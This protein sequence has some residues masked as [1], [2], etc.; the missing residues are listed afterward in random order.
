MDV[1]TGIAAISL[2]S[3]STF[4]GFEDM[5]NVAEDESFTANADAFYFHTLRGLDQSELQRA[6]AA[7]RPYH[8]LT[9]AWTPRRLR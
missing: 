3:V 4:I 8:S 6:V 7:W 2:L 1:W 5:V 9:W